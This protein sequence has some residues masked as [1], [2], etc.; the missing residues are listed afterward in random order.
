MQSP[1]AAFSMSENPANALDVINFTDLSTPQA[2]LVSWFW[3]FG[4]SILSSSQNPSHAYLNQGS[5]QIIFVVTDTHGCKDT[6]YRSIDVALLPQVPTAFTPNGDGHNDI[7][8]VRGGPFEKM[9]FRVYN[10]WG[11]LV[12]QSTDQNI[13]WDGTVSGIDQPMSVYVW[14]LDV[15]SYNGKKVH[16]SGDVTLMR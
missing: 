11:E 12:F 3:N 14:V 9:Q 6:A 7:L 4:D 2:N 15:D 13:G 1:N 16:K 8:Y 10:N 5:Y